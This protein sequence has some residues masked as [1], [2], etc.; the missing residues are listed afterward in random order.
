MCS[1]RLNGS[2]KFIGS[3]DAKHRS[4]SVRIFW[5]FKALPD[6]RGCRKQA[7]T[8]LPK[9]MAVKQEKKFLTK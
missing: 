7:L 5:K 3:A 2:F 8:I 6:R 9:K 1:S 4:V